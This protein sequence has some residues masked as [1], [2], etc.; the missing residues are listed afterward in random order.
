MPWARGT[1]DATY[2]ARSDFAKGF[3]TETGSATTPTTDIP[4]AHREW[5]MLPEG[6]VVL[7]DRVDTGSATRN[8]YV[9]LHTNTGG[10]G[11]A[12]SNG[13]YQGKIGS[14]QVVIHPVSIEGATPVISQPPV[15]DCT[16]DCEYPCAMC[17]VGRFPSDAYRVTIPGP[18]A[19]GI[20]VIDGLALTDQPATIDSI[21][22]ATIDPNSQN[23]GVIGASVFRSSMQSYV[24]ASSAKD[25][26]SPTT[27]TYGVP[28][29]SAGRHIVFDAP[30]AS[31]GTSAVTATAQSGR[32]VVSITA[33]SGG[34]F[35]GQP[36]MFSVTNATS[37]CTVA[38]STTVTPGAPPTGGGIDGG[39]TG[40]SSGGSGS[41]GSADNGSGSPSGSKG[42][43]GC[44]QVGV[45]P[46]RTTFLTPRLGSHSAFCSPRG[47]VADVYS[48]A[49]RHAPRRKEQALRRS[50]RTR[51]RGGSVGG[52]DRLPQGSHDF[53]SPDVAPTGTSS[54]QTTLTVPDPPPLLSARIEPQTW[55]P[56]GYLLLTRERLAE[57]RKNKGGKD[58]DWQALQTNAERGFTH[59]IRTIEPGEPGRRLPRDRRDPLCARSLQA[60]A[61]ARSARRRP[62]QL[63]RLRRPYAERRVRPQ[64]LRGRAQ[65]RNQKRSWSITSRSGPTSCGS[66]TKGR[67]GG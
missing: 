30:E 62:R 44:S 9:T 25:G 8:M 57:L 60:R 49:E 21:N 24:V 56:S 13:V 18:F 26:V 16:L 67:D 4:Y 61:S 36:L 15:A 65:R 23:T 27:M 53:P 33:G 66:T 55:T 14:S 48:A 10:G 43:C 54:T 6:E 32:C 3:N 5:V 37:G 31:D 59:P 34:G 38:D 63:P 20:H 11:L 64:L 45:A 47:G 19:V 58:R 46:S 28:G 12:L 1:S 42:G 51:D 7:I 35:T 2:A 41:G 50:G 17:D 39:E 52:F 40:G 29:G 22:D